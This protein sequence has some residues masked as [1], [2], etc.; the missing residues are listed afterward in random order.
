MDKKYIKKRLLDE[1]V[2]IL[3]FVPSNE[4]KSLYEGSSGVIVPTY[5]GQTN[6]PPLE[7]WAAKVPL[8]YSQNFSEQAGN[9]AEYIDYDDPESIANAIRNLKEKSRYDSLVKNGVLR[10]NKINN[11]RE[12]AESILFSRLNN[13]S[14]RVALWKN[15]ED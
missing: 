5:F 2:F 6:L 10:L 13:F 8:I 3:G 7:A 9:A 11:D 1:Q 4:V 12:H 15:T 14:R